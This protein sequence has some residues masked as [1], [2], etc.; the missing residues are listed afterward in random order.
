MNKITALGWT[1]A[2]LVGGALGLAVGATAQSSR[3]AAEIEA[4]RV[5]MVR[6]AQRV[7][8]VAMQALIEMERELKACQDGSAHGQ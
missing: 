3:D 7:R 2:I 1:I 8:Y 6:D 5:A 4:N